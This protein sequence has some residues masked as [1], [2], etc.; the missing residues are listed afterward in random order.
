MLTKAIAQQI[1]TWLNKQQDEMV[2]LLREAAEIETPSSDPKSQQEMFQLLADVFHSMGYRVRRFPGRSSG[3]QMLAMPRV[4]TPRSPR[5]LLIGH[6]DTVWPIGTLEKMPVHLRGG[7]LYGPGVYDM[8]G[9]LVQAIFALKSIGELNL[10]PSV[11]PVV[12]VNSD[13]EIGSR[14]SADRICSL[15][16]R[17]NRA[18]VVEPSLGP[19][20]H[21]KTARK[22]VGRFV[23]QVA[24]KAAHAGLDPEKGIS[25]ILEMTHVVQALNA[26]N[27]P[28][29]G[30]TVNVGTIHGGSS[31]NVVA[32]ESRAEV[33]VRVRTQTIAA[34]IE[35]AIH[36]IKPTI[37]GTK[38]TITGEIA[39]PPLERTPNNRK[40]WQR[41]V[42]SAELL[43]LKIE[44]ATA[45]GGSDGNWTSL[46][47][48]TLDGLGAIGDGAH[49]LNEHVVVETM[50]ERAALLAC[51][52]M[53][54]P[55][56]HRPGKIHNA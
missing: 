30:T 3:G 7:R 17:V 14:E 11:T 47:T 24:G 44:E 21:L 39:R 25:A 27:D 29:T 28:D 53:G 43:G 52:I 5:Q 55:I 45:G 8:K 23:V 54:P 31:P 19:G 6:V 2:T 49:A 48:P 12:F 20:G 38:L 51:L 40:I 4:K 22:G 33:D 9:G 15:A 18:M 26:L 46:H 10:S 56:E 13:E 32:A 35:K 37:E 1:L 34:E 50:P 36:S 42:D 41:A 16:K